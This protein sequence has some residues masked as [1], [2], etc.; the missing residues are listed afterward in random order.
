MESRF[1]HDFSQ[2]RVHTDGKAA[3]SSQAVNALAYTVGRN[4]VFNS[5][6]Y[7]PQTTSGKRLLAHELTHVIQQR[8]GS[9]SLQTLKI[10]SANDAYEREADRA[11][12]L[13]TDCH[14]QIT[15]N[16]M[17]T[18]VSIQRVC[19]PLAIDE[20]TGCTPSSE[21]VDRPRYLF[22]VNCDD[23]AR[24]NEEDLR[25]DAQAIADGEIVEIHGLA[26]IEGNP[27]FNQ[28]LSCAR[29]LKA[30][31]VIE[32]VLAQRGISATIRVFSH[33]ATPGDATQQRSVVVTR[34]G[35]TTTPPETLHERICGPDATDWFV[36]QTNAAMGD[37]RVQ[38]IRKSL[39]MASYF[40]ATFGLTARQ[41]AE[42]GVTWQIRAQETSLGSRAPA[43]GP[44]ISGQM[45][46]GTRSELA[47]ITALAL[48]LLPPIIIP[49]LPAPLIRAALLSYYVRDAALR[50][51]ALVDHRADYDF[52]AHSMNHP[53]TPNCPDPAC[54]PTCE[55]GVITLCP[56]SN[57][58][59]QNCY[60]SDLPGNV[61][62]GQIGRYAGWSELA[63]Q[64]GSQY[65]ELLD[66]IPRP[67][68]PNI[69]W[70]S[71][72]DTAMI[73]FG[74]HNLSLPLT[75]S[76]LCSALPPARGHFAIVNCEDCT[77]RTYPTIR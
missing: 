67:A 71:P 8:K 73:H 4:V 30:K 66:V 26:S 5:G 48:G 16:L 57:P 22:D 32:E 53:R 55:V 21:E 17:S 7:T 47:V 44:T 15:N 63:L 65:A 56:G 19:G 50:W 52:K 29:A 39:R 14:A 77:D 54:C 35:Q 62:F 3:E 42:A 51:K 28:H 12:H 18:V 49:R 31:T 74:Y 34:I 13:V 72:E 27:V 40:A 61:F 37:R 76:V 43:R 6:Q 75:R 59:G 25:A 23:F 2:V 9:S 41:V 58:S 69:T 38:A 1:G 70:D 60:E 11:A 10:N 68:R 24:G 64:L 36:D 46:A 33:G 45:A 20:P